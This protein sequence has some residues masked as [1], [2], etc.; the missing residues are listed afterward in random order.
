M[1]S[2]SDEMSDEFDV[3]YIKGSIV[4]RIRIIEDLWALFKPPCA[5]DICSGKDH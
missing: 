4:V 1:Q 3:R 2:F 5:T